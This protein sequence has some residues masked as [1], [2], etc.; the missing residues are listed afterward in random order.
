MF[1]RFINSVCCFCASTF[2][3]FDHFKGSTGTNPLVQR[4]WLAGRGDRTCGKQV[5]C[6]FDTDRPKDGTIQKI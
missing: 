3:S 6:L 1:L 4:H 2:R 5:D